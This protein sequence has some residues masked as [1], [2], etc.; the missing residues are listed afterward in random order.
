M[1]LPGK[2]AFY[3]SDPAGR[4]LAAWGPWGLSVFRFDY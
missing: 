3:N 1:E 4:A 2:L